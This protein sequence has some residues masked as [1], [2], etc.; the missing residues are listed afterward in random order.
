[1]RAH[2]LR[3]F[4]GIDRSV[5]RAVVHGL[6][7]VAACFPRLAVAQ[8]AHFNVLTIPPA[9]VG[10]CLPPLITAPAGEKFRQGNRL[11]IRTAEPFQSREIYTFIDREGQHTGLSDRSNVSL[12]VVRN[13]GVSITAIVAPGGVI[14]GLRMETS[15]SVPDSVLRAS[16]PAT[17]QKIGDGSTGTSTNRALDTAEQSGVRRMI[18][19]IRQRCP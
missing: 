4:R 16:D 18:D 8:D 12:A 17:I 9:N 1:M 2:W 19:F 6:V 11:V 10:T 13:Q 5:V 14:S 15:L 7:I 3:W